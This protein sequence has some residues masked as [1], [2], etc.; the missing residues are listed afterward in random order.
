M[1]PAPTVV[2]MF[3][4]QFE[5]PTVA[6]TKRHTIRPPRKRQIPEG[7]TLSLRVWTGLPY[8]SPQREFLRVPFNRSEEIQI[9]ATGVS[10]LR[11]NQT[12]SDSFGDL[13]SLDAFARA[14]GFADWLE[15]VCWFHHTH[16]LPFMGCLIHWRQPP[17]V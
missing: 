10:I 8:R 14:D 2:V 15:M 13:E 1:K 3:K 7:A 17:Q 11:S 4:P 16:G 5:A 6:G 12:E 9:H